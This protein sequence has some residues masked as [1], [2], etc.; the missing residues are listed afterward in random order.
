MPKV[1]IVDFRVELPSGGYLHLQSPDEVDLW[2]KALKR[3]RDDYVLAKHN[4]LVNLGALLQQQ[5]ILFRCQTAI[6]GMEAEIDKDGL[7]TGSY[8][9]VDLDGTDLAAY[10]KA[11]TAAAVEMARLERSLGID[12]ST[13]EQ[14]GAHTVD[15]YIK[16]LKRAAHARGI[17]I[18]DTVLEY[19]RIWKELSWRIRMLYHADSQDRAYHHVTPKSLL[20][21]LLSEVE[22]M[23]GK[24]KEWAKTTGKL[25]V[26]KL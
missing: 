15:N 25:Y 17:H 14:G 4:D 1:F 7:P 16:T 8:R 9:R 12:R 22:R 10:Q 23:E 13:R 5:I 19:Q 18:T 3:Y 20:D 2:E 6:N 24:E 11:L 26:G 21:W